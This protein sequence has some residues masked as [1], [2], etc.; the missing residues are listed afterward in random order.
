MALKLGE[1]KIP[2][3]VNRMGLSLSPIIDKHCKQQN[4]AEVQREGFFKSEHRTA[5]GVIEVETNLSSGT[6]SVDL[7][8]ESVV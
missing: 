2:G 5:F 3:R 8:K 6:T 7:K 4:A 1:I